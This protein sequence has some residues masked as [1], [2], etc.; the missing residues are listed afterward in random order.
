MY[1]SL[2]PW[3]GSSYAV[4]TLDDIGFQADGSRRAM[5]LE[6]QAAGVAEDGAILVPSP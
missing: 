5:E 3:C 2:L 6:E 4:A 1:F